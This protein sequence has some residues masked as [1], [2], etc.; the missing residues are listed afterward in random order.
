MTQY[1]VFSCGSND[2]VSHVG[3]DRVP[4]GH[5]LVEDDSHGVGAEAIDL[6][7]ILRRRDP[8]DLHEH[9]VDHR[10]PRPGMPPR[11]DEPGARVG[12]GAHTR[13]PLSA[14]VTSHL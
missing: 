11:T 6:G 9:E 10:T 1:S 13:P 14:S 7:R 4:G 3:V 2:P 12:A 8:V 5:A